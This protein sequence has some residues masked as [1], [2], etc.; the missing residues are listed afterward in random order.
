MHKIALIGAGRIGKIHAANAMVHPDLT[1][2]HVVDPFAE[3]AD[4]LAAETGAAVASLEAVLAD[5]SV[6]GVIVAVTC[7]VARMIGLGHLIL[8]I[9]KPIPYGGI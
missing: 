4:A 7:L 8:R 9:L 5:A 1:L 6:A 2:A 3:N